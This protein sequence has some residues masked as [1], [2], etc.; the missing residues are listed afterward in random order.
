MKIIRIERESAND[1]YVVLH[2]INF[3]NGDKVSKDDI[4]FEVEGQKTAYEIVSPCDGFFFADP[5]LELEQDIEIDRIIG[6][7]SQ[8]ESYEEKAIKSF[9][10]KE[11][12]IDKNNDNSN[13]THLENLELSNIEPHTFAQKNIRLAVIG[14]GAGLSQVLEITKNY[15]H[16]NVEGVYDDILFNKEPSVNGIPVVG[17]INIDSI[18]RDFSEEL[19]DQIVISINSDISFREKVFIKLKEN[20]L[21]FANLIHPTVIIDHTSKIGVGNIILPSCH[22]GPYAK[23]GDNNFISA[24]CNIEHHCIISSNCTFGPGVMFS[25]NVNVADNVKF[26]TGIFVEPKVSFSEDQFIE[27]GSIVTKNR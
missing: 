19:F 7:V 8:D 10:D 4:L 14:G 16:I 21:D 18:C 27:S 24:F 3:K 17:S 2:N 25:G 11:I 9:L 23:I 6:V 22:I 26:G 20:N 12:K 15:D 13:D 1:E 5:N